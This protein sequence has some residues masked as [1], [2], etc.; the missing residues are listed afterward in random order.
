MSQP[1]PARN[2]GA[3]TPTGTGGTVAH[4]D[5]HRAVR[6]VAGALLLFAG[7][8]YLVLEVVAARGWTNPPYSYTAN[9]ISDLGAPD[10]TTYQERVV[11]SPRHDAMNTAFIAHGVLVL[12]A[13]LLLRGALQGR[14]RTALLVVAALEG[15][16]YGLTGVFHG[17]TAATADGTVVYHYTGATLAILGGNT[18]A[19]LAGRRWRELGAPRWFGT[20]STALGVVGLLGVL[21][22]AAL[23]TS[24]YAGA[25][26][27]VAVDAI[28]AWDLVAG[29]VLLAFPPA[30]SRRPPGDL[31]FR[32]PT[33][34]AA[35]TG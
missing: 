33:A 27:R 18:V 17:S 16:G 6:G 28:M 25:A 8:Q 30:A 12:V 19:L 3:A 14:T 22:L 10:C 7:L 29:V 32:S 35:P 24:P 21:A 5:P 31:T 20:A 2:V 26:E 13:W 1:T 9:Y 4:R 23:L 15:L 34:A 11:C